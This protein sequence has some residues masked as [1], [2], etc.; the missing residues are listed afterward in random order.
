ML[1][2][3]F[4]VIFKHRVL[5]ASNFYAAKQVGHVPARLSSAWV[6]C[7]LYSA[8]RCLSENELFSPIFWLFYLMT[9]YSHKI[10]IFSPPW[11]VPLSFQQ[12]ANAVKNLI[13]MKNK[14]RCSEIL[15]LYFGISQKNQDIC[16][17]LPKI[18]HNVCITKLLP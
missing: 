13:Y 1:N 17:F 7:T 15:F 9:N 6:S 16:T 18:L 3:T 12:I 14:L 4:S 10:T 8:T 2:E 5:K 11:S